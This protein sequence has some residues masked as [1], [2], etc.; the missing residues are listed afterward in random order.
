MFKLT[1]KPSRVAVGVRA[2]LVV[3]VTAPDHTPT[4]KVRVKVGNRTLKGTLRRG[5]ATVTLPAFARPGTAKVKVAY[6]GDTRT[7]PASKTL[8][9]R[10]RAAL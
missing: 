5:K 8:R 2:R 6:A 4:G 1:V 3:R 10:V 7:L 9:I